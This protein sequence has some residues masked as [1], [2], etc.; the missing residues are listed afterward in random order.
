MKRIAFG[1]MLSLLLWGTGCGPTYPKATLTESLTHLCKKEYNIDVSVQV[2]GKTL[3]VYVPLEK[4]FDSTLRLS[5]EVGNQ[6]DGVIL[7]TSRV[8]LSTDDPPDFYVVV[9]EDKRIPGVELRLVRYTQDIRRLNYGDLSRSEYTKR[10]VF[11]F[12]LGLGIFSG[13]EHAFHLEEVKLEQFLATQMAQRIK[14]RLDEQTELQK[15]I[16][17]RSVRGEFVP[18]YPTGNEG[19]AGRFVITL[20]AQELGMSLWETQEKTDEK[21]VLTSALVVILEVLKGYRFTAFDSVELKTPFLNHTLILSREI[22]ELYRQKKVDL[23]ELLLPN[24]FNLS[25]HDA[26]LILKK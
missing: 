22:L 10:M 3:G 5:P 21:K 11:E 4:L 23:S 18:S 8:V 16:E 2:V 6:L 9:A 17:V 25:P 26:E 15:D 7:A 1:C 12:G 19:P 14:A 24:P 20:E 13:E